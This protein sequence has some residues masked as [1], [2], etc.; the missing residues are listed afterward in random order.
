[1]GEGALLSFSPFRPALAARTLS[2]RCPPL[3][4]RS[5]VRLSRPADL[6]AKTGATSFFRKKKEKLRSKPAWVKLSSTHQVIFT[7][8]SG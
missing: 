2:A 5:N 3:L 7:H 6:W 8:A 4:V 1:V